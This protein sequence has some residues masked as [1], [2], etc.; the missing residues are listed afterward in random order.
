VAVGEELVDSGGRDCYAEFVVLALFGDA[1]DHFLGS[2]V[3]GLMGRVCG[4][5]VVP[6]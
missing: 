1:D 3:G 5:L 2:I 4:K 6:E